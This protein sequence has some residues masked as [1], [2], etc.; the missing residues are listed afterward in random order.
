MQACRQ[1]ILESNHAAHMNLISERVEVLGVPGFEVITYNDWFSQSEF[2]FAEQVI[3]D[4]RYE[5]LEILSA[6]SQ[7]IT[8]K[9]IEHILDTDNTQA[10]HGIEVELS[11]EADQQWRVTRERL[12]PLEQVRQTGKESDAG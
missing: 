7:R 1:S 10:S 8:F 12:L 2:E 3:A 5:G 11:L 9:T 6:E 4:I